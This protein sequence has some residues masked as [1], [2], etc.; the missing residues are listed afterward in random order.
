MVTAYDER[1]FVFSETLNAQSNANAM[2]T[3]L[4]SEL[5]RYGFSGATYAAFPALRAG[6]VSKEMLHYSSYDEKF[7]SLYVEQQLADDDYAVLHC[8]ND[9]RPA[10]WSGIQDRYSTPRQM[11]F[12]EIAKDYHLHEG[13]IIPFREETGFVLGGIGLA[14]APEHEADVL[15]QLGD[16]RHLIIGLCSAFDQRIKS[17]QVLKDALHLTQRHLECLRYLCLGLTDKEI[18]ARTGLSVKTV[19]NYIGVAMKRIKARNRHHAT[20]KAIVLGLVTI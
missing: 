5:A 1:L 13:L 14:I 8:M 11:L 17:P 6:G 16:T 3:V 18:A 20:A 19:E 15:S 7:V 12:N 10:L 2:W 4:N 9:E